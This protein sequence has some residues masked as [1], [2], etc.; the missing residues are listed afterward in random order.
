[1]SAR[2]VRREA[3]RSSIAA[4]FNGWQGGCLRHGA[5]RERAVKAHTGAIARAFPPPPVVGC[6]DDEAAE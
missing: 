4:R 3:Y 5:A 2:T 1:M 6:Y